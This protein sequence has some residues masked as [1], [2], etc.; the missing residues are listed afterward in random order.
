MDESLITSL[1]NLEVLLKE[2][3]LDKII[4]PH[5]APGEVHEEEPAAEEKN[6]F[7]IGNGAYVR[8]EDKGMTA[9]L[10]LNPPKV[11]EEF[12]SKELIMQFLVENKILKG[13]HTS[14]IAAIAK[15]HVYEREILVAKG[16]NPVAGKDGH[17]EFF[18]ETIDRRKPAIREDGTVDY[19]SMTSLSNVEEGMLIARYH[20]ATESKKG[21]DVFGKIIQVKPSKELPKLKGRGFSTEGNPDDYIATMTGKIDYRNGAI[22][23]KS[24]HEVRGDVDLVTGKIEFFG[25]IHVKGNVGAGVVIRSSRNVF[26]DGVVE[27]A[28]IYAGGDVVIAKGMQ[29]ALKGT[30]NAKGNVSA[31]FI[32]HAKVHA[33]GTVR[34]NTYIN[35]DVYSDEM[36]IAEGKNGLILGGSVRG[37]KGVSAAHIGNDAETKTYVACGYSQEEYDRYVD[38][39]HKAEELQEKLTDIVAR[40]TEILKRRRLGGDKNNEASDRELAHL[41]EKKDVLFNE[42]DN[43]E[44]EKAEVGAIIEKGK[45]S[46]IVANEKIFR[47]VTICLEGNIMRIPANTSY[48]RYKNEGGRIVPSVIVV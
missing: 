36:V 24:V 44:K 35:A 20:H 38:A 27:A 28:D 12:Y 37:L 13:Y 40:M 31:E 39:F 43:C 8:T 16:E 15:K 19:Y 23:I 46:V 5:D 30:I 45:G 26:V 3:S 2:M 9:Y 41:N 22:D 10:Y 32:E 25:D 34:S 18:F 33:Q 17:Y 48:M 6:P 1:N 14:N 7:C 47:G 42:L 11:G 29:G 4:E 21:F